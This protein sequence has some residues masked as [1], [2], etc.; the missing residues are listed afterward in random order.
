MFILYVSYV[1]CEGF[2]LI[3]SLV[4]C[5]GLSSFNSALMRGIVGGSTRDYTSALTHGPFF[6]VDV[7]V[8]LRLG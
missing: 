6:V 4:M 7:L 1:A 8:L 3:L 2:I 5:V